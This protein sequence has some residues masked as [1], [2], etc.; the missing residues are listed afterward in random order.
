MN[1]FSLVHG[2][3]RVKRI[4]SNYCFSLGFPHKVQDIIRKMKKTMMN[5]ALSLQISND[6]ETH[7]VRFFIWR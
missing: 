6:K 7:V 5:K 1:H 3:V 2:T 4:K